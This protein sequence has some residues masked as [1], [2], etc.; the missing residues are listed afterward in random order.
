MNSFF[1][2][3][4][5]KTLMDLFDYKDEKAFRKIADPIQL[6]TT[7]VV[8]FFVG[9]VQKMNSIK[10]KKITLTN[11]IPVLTQIPIFMIFYM[12]ILS[13]IQTFSYKEEKVRTYK[14]FE[15]D[16]LVL[17]QNAGTFIFIFC[18]MNSFHQ[19]Y[20]SVKFPTMRRISKMALIA[21]TFVVTVVLVFGFSAYISFGQDLVDIALYPSRPA[22]KD[23]PKDI[24]NQIL[25]SS[26]K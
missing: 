7:A 19:V 24:P 22:L 26:K 12:T 3:V 25:K 11:I 15:S 1:F 9:S 23:S 4:L 16:P 6:F 18:A 10:G 21:L 17:L 2:E 8:L 14:K 13:V 5:G 20:T